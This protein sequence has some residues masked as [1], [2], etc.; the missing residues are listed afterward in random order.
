M[1]M[2]SS[3]AVDASGSGGIDGRITDGREE[4]MPDPKAWGLV[5][6]P[7]RTPAMYGAVARKP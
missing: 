7:T 3:A 2:P 4:A 1:F 6:E 5:A